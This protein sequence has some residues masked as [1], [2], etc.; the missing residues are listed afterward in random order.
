MNAEFE[1]FKTVVNQLR[2]RLVLGAEMS[3]EAAKRELK[4]RGHSY[5]SAAPIIGRS[6]Q[7]ISTVLNKKQAS[8]PVL[9]AIYRLPI[10]QKKGAKA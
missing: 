10:R 3:S 4:K 7:W 5:R 2:E 1:R 8:R 6:Y 9:E